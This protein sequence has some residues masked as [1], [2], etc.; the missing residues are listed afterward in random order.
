MNQKCRYWVAVVD[1]SEARIFKKGEKF[2]PLQ[3]I[4]HFSQPHELTHTH[5]S[6]RPGRNFESATPERHAYEQKHD[7][8]EEQKH[9]FVKDVAKHICNGYQN[10]AFE[11]LV[12]VCPAH[13]MK[14]LKEGVLSL[15][16]EEDIKM[17]TKDL[18]HHSLEEVQKHID[19]LI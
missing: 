19:A 10:K 1:G 16:A 9:L 13:L 5:G 11:R 15:V 14:N 12:L 18:V 6:D 2:S 4:H 3:Q 7:W 8:H 17:I